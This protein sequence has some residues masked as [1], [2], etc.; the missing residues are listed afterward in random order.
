[1]KRR[2]RICGLS[3]T[4]F[5]SVPLLCTL[6]A[7]VAVS[8]LAG[9][10]HFQPKP[11]EP[12]KTLAA[13]SARSLDDPGLARYFALNHRSA[14][15]TGASWGLEPLT[16]AAFYFNPDLDVARADLAAVQ[17]G[18]VTAAGRQNPA[19]ALS[20][21]KNT[22]TPA[23]TI[24]PWILDFN[25]DI[26]L[27]TAGKRAHRIAVA[28]GLAD[29]AQYDLASA[30]WRVRSRVRAALLE[31]ATASQAETLLA[32]EETIEAENA[33][34]LEAQLAAGE[35][36]SLEATQ[37]RLALA[38]VQL[39]KRDAVTR[40]LAARAALA[41]AIGVSAGALEA[42]PLDLDDV[43]GASVAIPSV[44]ARREAMLNRAD[45]LGALAEYA[46]AQ[47]ALQLE[48]ARQYPDIHLGP[49]YEFDQGDNKWFLALSLPLPLVNRN[50]GPIAEAEAGRAA[51]AAR[52]VAV[53]A[54]ALGE[55]DRAVA[56]YDAAR[57]AAVTAEQMAGDLERQERAARARFDAGEV[58]RVEFDAARL[59]RVSAALGRLGALVKVQAA[60]GQLE[61][62]MQ[63]SAQPLDWLQTIPDRGAAPGAGG[64]EKRR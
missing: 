1:M 26:P 8:G 18:K 60:L 61:D 44:A 13:F 30:A 16:F 11:I 63:R 21:A 27:T 64:G 28:R 20:G 25:L 9:C 58:S 31:L 4:R 52:F 37:A 15:A 19:V 48:I 42:V 41:D 36:S 59:E 34:L 12:A 6:V 3:A 22:S 39:A 55:V 45:V 10:V 43:M 32:E 51:A 49:G 23:G 54:H 33:K 57:T 62:A 7:L 40:R 24:S 47:A 46:A 17:A 5:H 35:V 29:A 53:Q 50:Q 56:V 14:P 38:A 2:A